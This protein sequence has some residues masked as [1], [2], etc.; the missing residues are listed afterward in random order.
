MSQHVTPQAL[1]PLAHVTWPMPL[2]LSLQLSVLRSCCRTS[3]PSTHPSWPH[4]NAHNSLNGREAS[5]TGDGY[6]EWVLQEMQDIHQPLRA[7]HG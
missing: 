5:S 3:A 4:H 1:G 2:D 7:V 6:C